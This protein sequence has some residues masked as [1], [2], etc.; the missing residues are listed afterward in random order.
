MVD[1]KRNWSASKGTDLYGVIHDQVTV[2]IVNNI[3]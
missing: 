3:S 2:G 1:G